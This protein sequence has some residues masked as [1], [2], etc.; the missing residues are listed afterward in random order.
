MKRFL[1]ALP[2][3]SQLLYSCSNE[4]NSRNSSV[5]NPIDFANL[6]DSYDLQE[7]YKFQQAL[8]GTKTMM[9]LR[10]QEFDYLQ[11]IFP[12]AF[13]GF[14]KELTTQTSL[15]WGVIGQP[16]AKGSKEKD[17][18]ALYAG[19]EKREYKLGDDQ[20]FNFAKGAEFH[21]IV[22]PTTSSAGY[23]LAMNGISY[24]KK[25]VSNLQLL[26]NG[27]VRINYA[28]ETAEEIE[29]SKVKEQLTAL[30]RNQDEFFD[31]IISE[32]PENKAL[33]TNFFEILNVSQRIKG[34]SLNIDASNNKHPYRAAILKMFKEFGFNDEWLNVAAQIKSL[35]A[36]PTG[37]IFTLRRPATVYANGYTITFANVVKFTQ[38][39]K[40]SFKYVV[41]D[42]VSITKGSDYA[43]KINVNYDAK[44]GQLLVT[45]GGARDSIGGRLYKWRNGL[46]PFNFSYEIPSR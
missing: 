15:T 42:G 14:M 31:Q 38:V 25:D 32:L 11:G 40:D 34:N 24:N 12:G 6:G 35:D 44:T 8:L 21:G 33:V 7:A 3:V 2:I 1:W 23:L 9:S 29:I 5:T 43:A 27:L 26:R 17:L 41:Q 18:L 22:A 4:T 13:N 10:P 16:R 19:D 45:G 39:A 30:D 46:Q 20:V 28:D 37:V 36:T